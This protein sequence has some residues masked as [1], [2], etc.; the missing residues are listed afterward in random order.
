MDMRHLHRRR[1]SGGEVSSWNLCQEIP[2][3]EDGVKVLSG[4][5]VPG[6][7]E[8]SGRAVHCALWKHTTGY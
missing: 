6:K 3:K 2:D 8:V 4:G 7:G 5:G 1:E